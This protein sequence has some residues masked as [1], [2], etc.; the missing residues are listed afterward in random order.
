MG[1][2]K[3]LPTPGLLP[4][5]STWQTL[6]EP[7][8]QQALMMTELPAGLCRQLET[9]A[10]G[11]AVGVFELPL[12]QLEAVMSKANLAHFQACRQRLISAFPRW[13]DDLIKAQVEFI[14]YRD[15]RFPLLLHQTPDPP[16]GLWVKGHVEALGV[17]KS[18]A[19]VGT[20][21]CTPYGT[22]VVEVLLEQ[23]QPYAP[24]IVSGLAAGI[25][26]VAHQQALK[27]GLPTVAVLGTGLDVMFPK[28]NHALAQRIIEAGGALVSEYPLGAQPLAYR[29]PKRNRLI[30]GL[31]Q[32]TLVVEGPIKSGAL[33]TAY[34]ALNANRQV[35]AVP[36][37]VFSNQSQG[38]NRLIKEG[39]WPIHSGQDIAEACGWP[40]SE[41]LA[42]TSDD[43]ALAPSEPGMQEVK[44]LDPEGVLAL[45]TD[46]PVSFDTLCQAKPGLSVAALTTYLSLLELHGLVL[47]LPGGQYSLKR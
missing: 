40:L 17:V 31:T 46:D 1:C 10:Y 6:T 24:L 11:S 39:A 4:G 26:T 21:R 44:A 5:L 14:H 25:D 8:A 35:M 9:M 38:P 32:G 41:S 19:V 27:Y 7:M 37:S 33:I 3:D 47:A 42:V 20:R 29:F 30:A 18:L 43:E 45:L 23:L 15:S 34:D 36:G 13:I 16:Y 2:P 22:K 28:T 12:K